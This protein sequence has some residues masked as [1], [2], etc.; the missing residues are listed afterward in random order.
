MNSE[1]IVIKI[2]RKDYENCES[3]SPAKFMKDICEKPQN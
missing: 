2:F 3:F 1:K